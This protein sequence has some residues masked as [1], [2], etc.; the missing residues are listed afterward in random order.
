LNQ[1]EASWLQ[2]IIAM[3]ELLYDFS[4]RPEPFSRYSVKELWTRPYLARQ[5]L[6]YHLSQDTDLASRRFESI[7]RAVDWID[8]QL[9]L[10]EKSVCDLGCGP[11]LYSQRFASR[12]A[13]VTG[14]DFS[15]HSLDYARTQGPQAI[16]YVEA[17]YLTDDLPTG[18]DVVTLIYTD[19]CAL[20]PENRKML[21]GRMRRMLNPGGQIVLDVAGIGS[22]TN[23]KEM[24]IIEHNLMGGFWSAEDYVGLQRLFVYPEDCLS[25][26]RYLIVQP[27]E[28]WQI[29]NWTQYF[30]PASIE[31][32]LHNAG[33]EID[34][35][36]G[37]LC[38][39]PLKSGSDLIGIVARSV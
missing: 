30:S 4:K 35:M 7:D 10:S 32:E 26:D 29:Y 8:A 14:V 24:T 25:L 18:F 9:N 13:T 21:L 16:R 6:N 27:D 2:R 22:F 17:D 12:G 3:Y 5:M 31:K 1:F 34:P 23:K 15:T 11:G 39:T 28:A 20:S 19:L 37:D 36:A 38:G 33:F